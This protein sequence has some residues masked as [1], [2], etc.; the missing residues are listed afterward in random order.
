MSSMSPINC[1]SQT[2]QRL[3]KCFSRRLVEQKA[4]CVIMWYST[5][6]KEH[7]DE[8]KSSIS[9]RARPAGRTPGVLW[10]SGSSAADGWDAHR[11]LPRSHESH[12]LAGL[13]R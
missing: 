1:A 6:E 9:A 13:S 7:I 5:T 11:I 8:K 3:Y 10:A 2:T 4:S 12:R